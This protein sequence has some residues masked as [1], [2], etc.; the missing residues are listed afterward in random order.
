MTKLK[1]ITIIG[2]MKSRIY[3]NSFDQSRTEMF[4]VLSNERI[5]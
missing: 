4:G 1:K 2:L 5:S 3:R